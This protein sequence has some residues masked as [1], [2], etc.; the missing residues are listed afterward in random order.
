MGQPVAVVRGKTHG[1]TLFEMD[2]A[3]KL[4]TLYSFCTQTNCADGE[5]PYAGLLKARNGNFYGTT[6]SGGISSNCP[7][8]TGFGC[9]TV[10]EITP[11]GKLTTLYNFCSQTNCSDG[12]APEAGLVQASNGNFYGTTN[13]GGIVGSDGSP[14]GTIFEITRAGK[15]TT[16]YRFC[17]QIN[18]QG[19]CADGQAPN[20]RLIQASNGNFYGTTV[21][22][23]ANSAGT[24]FEVTPAGKLITLHNFCSRRNSGGFCVDGELPYSGLVQGPN[25]NLYGT[26]SGGGSTGYGSVFEI[27]PTGKLTS[28]Y[29]FCS[30]TNCADGDSPEA[31]LVRASNGNFYGTT[32]LGGVSSS[33][34]FSG[35]VIGCGTVFEITPAGKLTTLHSFCTQTGCADGEYPYGGLVQ[36]ANGLLYGTTSAG[37]DLTCDRGNGCGSVFSLSVGLAP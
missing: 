24:I 14:G 20:A 33:C 32:P 22:G 29:S 2:P 9:G 15:L 13:G 6:G 23:G 36:A 27:T 37:G 11:T 3:G 21:L 7:N 31:P 28:L 10:L 1:G 4:T 12:S 30:Q 18:S 25:G 35:I 26:T 8:P 17:S 34:T 16:L 19:S 5:L